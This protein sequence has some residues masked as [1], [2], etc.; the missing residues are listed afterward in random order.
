MQYLTVAEVVERL[1]VSRSFLYK[2]TSTGL[3]PST[4]VGGAIRIRED[5]LEAWL[6]KRTRGV[7]GAT[8]KGDGAG[9]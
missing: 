1:R 4:K 3:I 6:K 7:K 8:A 9:A 5:H 2:A